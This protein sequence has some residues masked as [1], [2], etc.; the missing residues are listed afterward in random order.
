MTLEMCIL[1]LKMIWLLFMVEHTT[2]Y[3][4]NGS[5]DEDEGWISFSDVK[6]MI[7]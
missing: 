3:P 7:I 4:F 2:Q 1:N 5:S 6:D